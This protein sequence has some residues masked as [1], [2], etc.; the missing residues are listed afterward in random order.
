MKA[1]SQ[2]RAQTHRTQTHTRTR[3]HTED[4]NLTLEVPL[5][6]RTSHRKSL[7]SPLRPAVYNVSPWRQRTYIFPLI[8]KAIASLL[9]L[10]FFPPPFFSSSDL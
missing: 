3:M 4:A 7:K 2:T 10:F 5:K 1:P 8:K 6:Y 9:Q